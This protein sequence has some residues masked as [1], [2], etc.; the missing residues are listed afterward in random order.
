MQTNLSLKALPA[1]LGAVLLTMSGCS[2]LK[3]VKMPFTSKKKEQPVNSVPFGVAKFTEN[4]KTTKV[5]ATLWTLR[6]QNGLL[7]KRGLRVV[8][9]TVH[10]CHH[11]EPA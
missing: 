11:V 9:L 3:K 5:P 8:L 7:A 4:N 10:T 1:L 2:T 6:N